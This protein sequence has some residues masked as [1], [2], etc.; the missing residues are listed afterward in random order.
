MD[1]TEPP[2]S[3]EFLRQAQLRLRR[4]V[5]N[6]GIGQ[7]LRRKAGQSLEFREFRSYQMGDDIRLVDWRASLRGGRN[8]G[9]VVRVF[10]AEERMTLLIIVDT[11]PAMR[12]PEHAPKLLAALWILRALTEVAAASGDEVVLGTLFSPRDERPVSARGGAAPGLARQF[13]DD[14]WA[15]PAVDLANVP[16]ASTVALTRRLR[17][18]SA[19]VLL[20]DLLFEDPGGG[21]AR[22]VR[23]SQESW[24]Q[25]FVQPMDSLGAELSM[26][27]DA[28]RIRVAA[29]EGRLLDDAPTV[30]NTPWEAAI[31]DRIG[32]H[33]SGRLADWAG[34]GLTV[35]PPLVWPSSGGLSALRTLF[36]TGFPASGLLR[37][38]A[39][40]GG[41]G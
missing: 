18:A 16:T 22:F 25:V 6:W 41:A 34:P 5:P 4:T 21:I 40:R 20:S 12:L 9:R 11:R 8:G 26:A 28:G 23:A 29:T 30:M 32:A 10:E 7:H 37:G 39:A 15:A 14:L 35:E 19:V 3:R 1:A 24:R 38:I 36:A 17:P 13:A 33:L 31:R 2:I 27:R